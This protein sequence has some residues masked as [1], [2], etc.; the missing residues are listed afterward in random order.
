M[1]NAIEKGVPCVKYARISVFAGLYF[2][3][4][5]RIHDV[6]MIEFFVAKVDTVSPGTKQAGVQGV[7]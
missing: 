5:D 4:R 7:G 3:W 1:R 2:L 6:I